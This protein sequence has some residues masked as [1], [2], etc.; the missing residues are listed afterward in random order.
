MRRS[1]IPDLS[2][3]LAVAAVTRRILPLGSGRLAV[4]VGTAL[5]DIANKLLHNVLQIPRAF[6]APTHTPIGVLALSY[7][8]C[9]LY[10]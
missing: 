2:V 5:P 10:P 3:H 8:T 7:I 4:I 1:A 6:A 9:L